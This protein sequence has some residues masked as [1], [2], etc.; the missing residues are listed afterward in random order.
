MGTSPPSV[1]VLA[2]EL[3]LQEAAHGRRPEELAEAAERTCLRLRRRL[4]VLI[5]QR[6]F[7]AMFDRALFLAAAEDPSLGEIG[8]DARE[9]LGLIG[10]RAFARTREPGETEDGLVAI[11]SHFIGLLVAFLGEEL[12]EH[13]VREAWRES[14]PGEPPSTARRDEDV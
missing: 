3:L 5:G 8:Y 14:A 7:A 2:R 4:S 10:A 9:E 12:A 13:L 1:R 6:G 11:F